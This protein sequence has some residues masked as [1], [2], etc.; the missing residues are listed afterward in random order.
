MSATYANTGR[1]MRL[2][3]VQA[4]PGRTEQ[5]LRKF[6]TTSADVVRNEPGNQGYFFGRSADGADDI[7][8]F[9]SFW[10]NLDAVKRRFGDD[11]QSS[12][13]PPGY[14]DL[15]EECSLCQIDL[16]AGWHVREGD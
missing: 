6:E 7:V 14:E 13:L 11:W 8:I 3:Q 4:K 10:D 1:I 9:A 5:L 15:I 16:T 12:F 2:F